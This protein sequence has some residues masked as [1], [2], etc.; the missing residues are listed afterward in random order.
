MILLTKVL[1][2]REK[3]RE[4]KR[5]RERKGREVGREREERRERGRKRKKKENKGGRKDKDIS[6][7]DNQECI[8]LLWKRVIVENLK[9]RKNDKI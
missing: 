4:K 3:Q 9:M 6:S 5:E 2:V 1:R 7:V 8:M